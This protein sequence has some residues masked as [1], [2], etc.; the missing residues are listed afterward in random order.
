MSEIFRSIC[1]KVSSLAA[2]LL[3]FQVTFSQNRFGA[4][5]E[6][7]E[8]NLPELGGR[9][10]LMVYKDGAL[11]YSQAFNNMSRRQQTAGKI[12]ARIQG[13]EPEEVLQDYTPTTRERIA[14]ASKWLSAALVLTFVDEGK[15][16]LSDTVGKYLPAL[17]RYGKGH[18]RIWHCLSHT[19]G[20]KE[21][22][23]REALGSFQK[24][25]TM[26]QYIESILTYPMEGEPGKVFR[27]GNTG[28]QIAAAVLEKISGKDFETLFAERIAGPLEMKNT[29]FGK[30]GLPLAAGG[31]WSTP[32]DYMNFLT[33]LL[34]EG[35]FKGKR[36]LSKALVTEMMKNKL[37]SDCLRAYAP[38]EAGNWGYGLGAWIIDPPLAIAAR[39]DAMPDSKPGAAATSPGLFG[40]FPWVE[41]EKKYAAFLFVYNLQHKGRNQLYTGLKRLVDAAVQ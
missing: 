40:S 23:L 9:A 32:E 28:L 8:Q 25:K 12:R 6:W 3:F 13:K 22:A 19:T 26:D 11:Q 31:A 7:M 4:V 27:Y 21:P 34:Q 24:I 38:E 29:D 37:G 18:I 16:R 35:E 41:N 20:I 17:S 5:T 2:F 39:K 36:I 14:S 33:M 10:V 15:L 30:S 1:R